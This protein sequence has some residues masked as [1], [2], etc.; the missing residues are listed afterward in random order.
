MT[1]SIFY[2]GGAETLRGE[3]GNVECLNPYVE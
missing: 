3:G 2:R 1:S